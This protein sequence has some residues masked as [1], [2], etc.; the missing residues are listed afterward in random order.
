MYPKREDNSSPLFFRVGVT[1]ERKYRMYQQIRETNIKPPSLSTR[2]QFLRTLSV[3]GVGGCCLATFG[4]ADAQARETIT[5]TTTLH[6]YNNLSHVS[7]NNIL[8]FLQPVNAQETYRYAAWQVL[9]PAIKGHQS[10]ALSNTFSGAVAVQKKDSTDYTDAIP[11]PLGGHPLMVTD[12]NDQSLVIGDQDTSIPLTPT[13]VGLENSTSSPPKN[14]SCQ[15]YVNNNLVVQTNNTDLTA[16][17][18]GFI[19]TFELIQNIYLMLGPKPIQQPTYTTQVF[20]HTAQFAVPVSASD[21]YFEVYTDSQTQVDGFRQVTL[22][23]FQQ[24]F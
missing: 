24:S 9:N 18:P 11:L 23:D 7:A 2:R 4:M 13:Q 19:S 15:W 8:I 20:N 21:L 1:K 16:L 5:S 12:Q 6:F 3:A 10:V 17:T 14:I 22:A